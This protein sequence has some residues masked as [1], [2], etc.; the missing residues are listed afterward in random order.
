MM[1]VVVKQKAAYEMRISD[2]SSDVWSSDLCKESA[3]PDTPMSVKNCFGNSV[4]F[5]RS[6]AL[7]HKSKLNFK[8]MEPRV[9]VFVKGKG[10]MKAMFGLGMY[11]DTSY[12]EQPLLNLI[13]YPVSQINCCAF[14]LDMHSKHLM[15]DGDPAQRLL[16]MV[17]WR[18]IT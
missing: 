2:W 6:Q 7:L 11:L 5:R 4:Q 18:E 3:A 9:N 14:C 17:E 12:L 8:I 1:V 10:A 16:V 15:V 13:Y